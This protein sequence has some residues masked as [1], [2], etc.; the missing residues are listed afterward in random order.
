MFTYAY[1]TNIVIL[2]LVYLLPLLAIFPMRRGGHTETGGPGYQQTSKP[3]KQTVT[4]SQILVKQKC[5]GGVGLTMMKM[6]R[7]ATVAQK[8]LEELE[9]LTILQVTFVWIVP[10]GLNP[11]R[12]QICTMTT[13]VFK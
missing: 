3:S 12:T 5:V 2:L 13:S 8:N 7:M 1:V 10:F 4:E 11:A 9:D 6:K